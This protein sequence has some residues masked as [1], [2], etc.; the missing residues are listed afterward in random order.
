MKLT[1]LSLLRTSAAALTLL[2][3]STGIA[4]ANPDRANPPGATTPAPAVTLASPDARVLA[5]LHKTNQMEITMGQMAVQKAQ[6]PAVKAYG[7]KLIRDHGQSDRDI[8]TMAGTMQLDLAQVPLHQK[9]GAERKHQATMD[10]LNSLTGAAFDRAF[11]DAMIE[12]HQQKITSISAMQKKLANPEVQSLV[13]KTLPVLK[14]HE[15]SAER[16]RRELGTAQGV[17][18]S[19]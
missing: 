18:P 3:A 2:L 1:T 8:T 11:I 7:E 19:P 15:Q 14:D 5:K 10:K 12:G 9:P 16:I 13:E 4:R 17:Q 6:S